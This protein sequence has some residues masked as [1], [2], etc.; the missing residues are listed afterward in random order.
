MADPVLPGRHGHVVRELR[1]HGHGFRELRRARRDRDDRRRGVGAALRRDVHREGV[2]ACEI[3][4]E[5]HAADLLRC[6]HRERVELLTERVLHGDG[7]VESHRIFREV[8]RS[9]R[10]HGVDRERIGRRSLDHGKIVQKRRIVRTALGNVEVDDAA[11][12]RGNVC[13]VR[14]IHVPGQDAVRINEK[15]A[16][17]VDGR[18]DRHTALGDLKITSGFDCGVVRLASVGN[19]QIAILIDRGH[20]RLATGGNIGQCGSDFSFEGLAAGTNVQLA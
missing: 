7:L 12:F 13:A 4:R 16:V 5:V 15:M 6:A 18:F 1:G 3:Q 17:L 9:L 11:R 10:L 8:V 19:D 14:K 20:I 2:V